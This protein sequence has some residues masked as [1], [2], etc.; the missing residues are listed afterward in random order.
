MKPKILRT[1][2]GQGGKR[3]HRGMEHSNPTEHIKH[4]QKHRRREQDKA[5]IKE[6]IE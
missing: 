5:H 3:G 2:G 6:Q 4:D 1:E